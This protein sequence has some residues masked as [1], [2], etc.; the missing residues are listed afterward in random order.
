[1]HVRPTPVIAV[2]LVLVALD[3]RTEAIDLLPDVVGWALVALGAGALAL[4]GGARWAIAAAVSSLGELSLP[5]R[6]VLVNAETGEPVTPEAP[7]EQT[8]EMLMF[9]AVSGGRLA[10]MALAVTAGALALWSLLRMLGRRAAAVGDRPAADAL[11]LLSWLAPAAWALPV[12]V[13]MAADLLG[14]A[15]A[16]DPVWNGLREL[17]ALPGIAALGAAAVVLARSAGADWAVPDVDDGPGPWD[18]M[19]RRRADPAA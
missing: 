5:S 10:L 4:R 7:A 18:R 2:G 8:S 3:M 13:A 14:D 15:G 19:R 17:A 1:M 16:Y 11:G 12:L 9:D 6:F